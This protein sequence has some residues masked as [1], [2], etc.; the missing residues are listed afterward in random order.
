MSRLVNFRKKA[1]RKVYVSFVQNQI[2]IAIPYEKDLFEPLL[3]KN[4]LDFKPVREYFENLQLAS[5]IVEDLNLNR[6]IWG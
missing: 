5:G 2:Y 6:R 3:F 4:M 1:G